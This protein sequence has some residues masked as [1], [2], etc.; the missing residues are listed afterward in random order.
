MSSFMDSR[1]AKMFGRG[2]SIAELVGPGSDAAWAP[3][4]SRWS[5]P[6][7]AVTGVAV[8]ARLGQQQLEARAQR[9]DSQAQ[10]EAGARRLWRLSPKGR[11][12]PGWPKRPTTSTFVLAPSSTRPAC[13]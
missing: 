8:T 13:C 3:K 7:S 11:N 1:H 10:L 12:P 9:H 5:S 2:K 4:M 6:A